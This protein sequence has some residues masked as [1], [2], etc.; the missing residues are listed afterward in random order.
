MYM[1][2]TSYLVFNPN[3]F[4]MKGW[5]SIS[6]V[7]SSLLRAVG[8]GSSATDAAAAAASIKWITKDGVGAL[9]R[10]LVG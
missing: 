3:F 1:A 6:L 5:I 10:F 4:V 7:T 8:V 2:R 9:G